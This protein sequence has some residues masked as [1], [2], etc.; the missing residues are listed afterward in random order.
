MNLLYTVLIV[1]FV[2]NHNFGMWTIK[3]IKVNVESLMILRRFKDGNSILRGIVSL[4]VIRYVYAR[5]F[6]IL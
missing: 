1:V 3:G 5:F 4:F 6:F 2:E